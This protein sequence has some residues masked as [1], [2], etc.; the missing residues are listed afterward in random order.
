MEEFSKY[1]GDAIRRTGIDGPI[2][3]AA[4]VTTAHVIRS[5]LAVPLRT[6]LPGE[7]S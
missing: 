3:A 6:S 1:P 4:T 5:A 7:R 2:D